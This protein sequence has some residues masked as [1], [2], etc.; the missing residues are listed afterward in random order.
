MSLLD[1]FDQRV[2][3]SYLGQI[4]LRI[5]LNE[6]HR[7][8]YTPGYSTSGN[9]GRFRNAE[10]VSDAISGMLW[11]APSFAFR[12]NDPPA[13]NA[14]AARLR[15]NYWYA[16][17]ITFRPFIQEIL[18]FPHL[19]KK[20]LMEANSRTAS[21][22]SRLDDMTPWTDPKRSVY[23]EIDLR[24]V[25]LAKKGI[26]ALVESTRAFY[27]LGDHRPIILN[28]QWGNLLILSAAYRDPVLH[29][30][31]DERLLQTLFQRT[32]EFFRQS[33]T[34]TSSL[35]TDMRILEGIQRELFS[36][37]DSGITSSF[38]DREQAGA[39]TP[40]SI[41]SHLSGL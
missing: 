36:P 35:R 17:A 8:L 9:E 30:Y 20:H 31:V 38:F 1:D 40:V 3:D 37:S 12:D 11:V 15:A 5:H 14:L 28:V 39:S 10:A 33:A 22:A 29:A 27:G 34:G 2:L 19:N 24:L 21:P 18:E 7:M 13:D 6:V 16:R 25:G 26:K 32:I 4:Y 41:S 23:G